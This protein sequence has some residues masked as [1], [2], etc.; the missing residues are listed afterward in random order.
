[1]QTHV[2]PD[3]EPTFI[4]V[5]LAPWLVA[6]V[7]QPSS[8]RGRKEKRKNN[9]GPKWTSCSWRSRPSSCVQLHLIWCSRG[10]W[11]AEQLKKITPTHLHSELQGKWLHAHC[12]VLTASQNCPIK[13][14]TTWIDSSLISVFSPFLY[15]FWLSV[16]EKVEGLCVILGKQ[17]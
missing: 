9:F 12:P 13:F 16:V 3:R 4:M 8:K 1:M 6:G 5:M 7:N 17:K 11:V 10:H 2:H 15:F 14:F